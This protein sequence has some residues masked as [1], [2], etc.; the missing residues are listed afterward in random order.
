MK[1]AGTI[2]LLLIIL[3]GVGFYF[4]KSNSDLGRDGVDQELF[5]IYRNTPHR[6]LLSYPA[7]LDHKSD[8]DERVVF[9]R[10][11]EGAVHTIAEARVAFIE[12]KAN[13]TY[14]AS[15]IEYIK[16]L[17]QTDEPDKTFS[18]TATERLQTITSKNGV[19][20][21]EVYLH[22]EQREMQTGAIMSI[23]KG[24]FFFFPIEHRATM[25]KVVIIYPPLTRPAEKVS[26]DDVHTIQNIAVS[27]R[28][29]PTQSTEE[30]VRAY[31]QTHISD[32]SPQKEQLG[33]TFYT[34]QIEVKDGTG[35]VH[36]EDGHSAYV[37]DF[38][39]G[40]RETGDILINTFT[41]RQ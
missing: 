14:E 25:S 3:F 35:T 30:L 23:S 26:A 22:G 2:I 27:L 15:V 40:V 36:Y 16:T 38:V 8:S 5:K 33:G 6:F 17:C 21:F 29:E 1:S 34:T 39:Y 9:G 32:L 7:N 24:P 41:I 37:A 11:E 12:G 31:I 19:R 20:G 13:D 10:T 28:L 4:K 18:C